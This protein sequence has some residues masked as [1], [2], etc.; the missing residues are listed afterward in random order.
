MSHDYRY[1]CE[2][3]TLLP[4][5]HHAR[6][7]SY[8]LERIISSTEPNVPDGEVLLG[9]AHDNSGHVRQWT[10]SR[11]LEYNGLDDPTL[12]TPGHFVDCGS[13]R[14]CHHAARFQRKRV[15]WFRRWQWRRALRSVP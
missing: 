9:W 13:V 12:S 14:P 15:G 11:G 4:I 3:F 10:V 5:A 2:V 7:L 6:H 1:H 8:W